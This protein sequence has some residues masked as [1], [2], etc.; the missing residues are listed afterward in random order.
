MQALREAIATKRLDD[1]LEKFYGM[2][3]KAVPKLFAEPN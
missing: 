2:R 3:R 1:F